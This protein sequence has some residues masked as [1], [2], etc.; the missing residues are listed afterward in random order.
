MYGLY[1]WL[2]AKGQPA[3]INTG[4]DI[5]SVG[6]YPEIY[7]GNDMGAQK[8]IR[9]ILQKPGMMGTT[10]EFGRFVAG[11]E[12]FD[13]SDELYVFSRAYD[14]WGV[15]DDHILFLPIIDLHTFYDQKKPRIK[16]AFYVGKGVNMGQHPEDAVELKRNETSDQQ[17][18]AEFLNECETLYVYDHLSAIMEVARLC[19]CKVVYLG[20]MPAEQLQKYEPGMNGL[21]YGVETDLDTK[22]FRA[23]YKDMIQVFEN[24]LEKFIDHTQK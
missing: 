4:I 16:K 20:D 23:H 3:F 17:K 22:E 5:S 6:I 1:G 19:G 21:G 11:P 12:A 24:K 8:V 14:E 7:S 18:L 13:P 2:L 10:D 15:D 9:Y